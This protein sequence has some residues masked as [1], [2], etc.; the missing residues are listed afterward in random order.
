MEK[1]NIEQKIRSVIWNFIFE[2][3]KECSNEIVSQKELKYLPDD[4]QNYNNIYPHLFVT[5]RYLSNKILPVKYEIKTSKVF[6]E[7]DLDNKS[8]KTITELI[9]KGDLS[10]NSYSR[11]FIPNSIKNYFNKDGGFINDFSGNLWGVKHLH[12]NPSNK[13]GDLLLY[14]VT[15]KD[16]IYFL[17]I[18]KHSEMFNKSVLEIIVN[19]YPELLTELRVGKM[20]DMP[21]N[22]KK[23]HSYSEQDV[24]EILK[25][26]GNIS[27]T[28][29]SEYYTSANSQTT[30]NIPISLINIA[31]NIS[32]QIEYGIELFLKH[33]SENNIQNPKI[34]ILT[35]EI[36]NDENIILADDNSKEAVV[37]NVDYLKQMRRAISIK[38]MN[39]E[40]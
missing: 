39:V 2:K 20:S 29:N 16:T 36:L 24:K 31:G 4:L 34:N 40:K 3:I 10:I 19:E 17:K 6:E 38:Q 37:F 30:G 9:K 26:G 35:H 8:I 1:K 5:E 14:Y 7:T 22:K 23:E 15:V 18:G 11:G 13:K 25:K 32:Y 21:I 12:L 28:I 27:Y 33:L